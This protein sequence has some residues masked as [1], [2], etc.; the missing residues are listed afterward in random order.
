MRV[1]AA[2]NRDLETAVE[3]GRFREDLYFRINVLHVELPPLRARG[4]DVLLLAQHFLAQLRERAIGK[5]VRRPLARPPRRSCSPTP[6]RATC[7]SSQNCIERAVAL[8]R[9]EQIRS[10]ICRSGS[11]TTARPIVL[12]ASDDPAELVPLEEVERRYIPRVLEAVGGNKTLAA[13][14]LGLDRKT[15]Y[16]KLER[17][18]PDPD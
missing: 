7:A 14:I 6:G 5:P 9:Y 18:G 4:S 12:V 1:V 11:A 10:R 13:R 3:E 15:L 17:S 16:R 8:T 2:T